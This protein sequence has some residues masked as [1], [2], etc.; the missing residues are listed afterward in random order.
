MARFRRSRLPR[1]K[2][3]LRLGGIREEDVTEEE[4][5][6]QAITEIQRII[7][8]TLSESFLKKGRKNLELFGLTATE[9]AEMFL[10][11]RSA[12][13]NYLHVLSHVGSEKFVESF[14]DLYD[15]INKL[16]EIIRK[17]E[18]LPKHIGESLKFLDKDLKSL[19]QTFQEERSK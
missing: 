19:L 14:E 3:P 6:S 4:K 16:G 13:Q 15:E 8:E 1:G 18:N 10:K 17:T 11:A 5:T 12:L 9:T 7:S 2:I